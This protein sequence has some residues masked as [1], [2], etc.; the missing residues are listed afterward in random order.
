MKV[1]QRA[2]VV[3]E[4]SQSEV[5]LVNAVRTVPNSPDV[6]T[7][8]GAIQQSFLM[9]NLGRTPASLK[10][11]T[12]RFRLP[13][14]WWKGE[15]A[16]N[17]FSRDGDWWVYKQPIGGDL[18]QDGKRPFDNA[19]MFSLSNEAVE[20]YQSYLKYK[21]FPNINHFQKFAETFPVQVVAH[22]E[23]VDVFGD[24]YTVRWQDQARTLTQNKLRNRH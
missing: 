4:N 3:I 8:M 16:R 11:L 10:D 2:Y 18:T 22:L 9:K 19:Y 7:L 14:D 5:V 15:D 21:I 6:P 17:R 24:S 23:Y 12:L 1:G 13:E 20:A